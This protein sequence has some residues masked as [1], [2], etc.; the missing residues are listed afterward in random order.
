MAKK[1]LQE[2]V[3]DLKRK[4]RE[5]IEKSAEFALPSTLGKA[6]QALVERKIPITTEGLIA[7]FEA[8]LQHSPNS[9]LESWHQ[10]ALA[11]LRDSV[12]HQ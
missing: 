3:A 1:T 7:Y 8:E 4:E 2:R 5:T 10:K 9:L 6:V 12:D 11:Y